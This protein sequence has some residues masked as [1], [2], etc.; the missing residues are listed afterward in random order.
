MRAFSKL[1]NHIKSI[2]KINKEFLG[3]PS[4]AIKAKLASKLTKYFILFIKKI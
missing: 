4:M 2:Y 3:F 1:L